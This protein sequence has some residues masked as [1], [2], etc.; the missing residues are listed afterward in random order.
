MERFFRQLIINTGMLWAL[1][2]CLIVTISIK[3]IIQ[4]FIPFPGLLLNL[5]QESLMGLVLGVFLVSWKYW[6]NSTGSGGCCG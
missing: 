2:L 4:L 5:N 3:S 6:R 1:I